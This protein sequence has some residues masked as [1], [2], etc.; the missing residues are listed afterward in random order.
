MAYLAS[1]HKA[2]S[3]RHAVKSNFISSA[4][5]SLIVAKSSRI[6]IYSFEGDG[7][8]LK[9]QFQVYGRITALLTLRPVDSPTDHLFVA[10]DSSNYL[11]VSWDPVQKRVRNEQ[12]ACDVSDK[13]LRNARCGPLYLADPAGRLL[14]LHIYQGTFISIPLAQSPKIMNKKQAKSNLVESF[15]NFDTATPIRFSELD[16]VDMAFLHDTANPVLAIL[17]NSA[18][19]G[20]VHMKTYEITHNGTEFKEWHMKETSLK[21]EPT[22]LIPVPGPVGGLLVLGTQMFCYFNP[23]NRTVQKHLLHQDRSFV[24]W[25]IID[26]QRYLLGDEDGRLHIL[27]IELLRGKVHGIKVEEIGQISVPSRLVYL[28]NGH[29]YVGSHSGDSQLVRLSS[30]EPKVQVIKTFTNLAPVTD[31]RVVDMNYSGLENQQQYSS[32]HMRIVSCSGGFKQGSLRSVKSGLV[33][34]DLGI[35]GDM[36]G[37]RGLWGLK[38]TPGN[39]FDDILVVSFIDETRVFQFHQ[40]DDPEELERFGGFSL[41]ERTLI[42][43]NVTDGKLLQVT[44]SGARLINTGSGEISSQLD[45]RGK[46]II[47]MASANEDTLIYVINGS[48]LFAVDLKAD[49]KEIGTRSFSNEISCLT[50]SIVSSTICAVGQWTTS[51]VSILTLPGL[52]TLSEEI[53]VRTENSAIPR[54][55]L[56][57]RILQ[58]QPPTLLVAMG[59]GTLFTFSVHEESYLLS[60]KKS[61]VLGTQSVYFQP[62]PLGNGLVNVFATCDHPSLIYGLEGRIAY[63]A[64][65]ADRTTHVTPFNAHGFP[66]SVAM[67]TEEDL[68]LAVLDFTR[69]THVR[70]LSTGDVVRR[71]AHLKTREVFGVL[72]INLYQDL[73]TGDEQFKCYVKVVDDI[74]FTMID[75]YEL[76]EAELIE[77]IMCANLSNGDET[78]SERFIVGTGFQEKSKDE[79]TRGRILVFELSDDRKLKLAAELVVRG[80]CKGLDFVNGKIVAALNRTVEMYSW[81]SP[82]SLKPKI[83]KIASYRTHSEPIDLGVRDN[84]IA[85]G[86]LMKGPSLLEYSSQNGIDYK[87][88][89]VARNYQTLWTTAIEL[90]DKETI[91]C[92]DAEGNMSIWRRDVNGVTDEDRKR[93]QLVGEIRIG[94]M[95]NRIRKVDGSVLPGSVV[96]PKAYC[97]TVDGSI[98]LLG[99]IDSEYLDLLMQLQSNMA[100]V[101]SGVGDL[102]FNKFRAYW[103]PSRSSEEPFRFVDG[104][105]IERFLELTDADAERVVDG[106]GKKTDGLSKG[107]DEIR[108]I[109][110]SLRRLH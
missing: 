55:L 11:T 100:K 71:V 10:S 92:G 46:G 65:T 35:L 22:M 32:G 56:L 97:A 18:H 39:Q 84:M 64:V 59:D 99:E 73:T 72:T 108:S 49:L 74:T 87:L 15:K 37:I 54:S 33:M 25:G 103:S 98:Y 66:N 44:P 101:I 36:V 12:A 38:S 67:A 7:L 8:S 13:F 80:S 95:V 61:I 69:S 20:E 1:I 47:N 110:E 60:Q 57:A 89:E 82:L 4:E 50:I 26:T 40:D 85:V 43:G 34:E 77:S 70:N 2:S 31:F 58:D 27:F 93:L 104:D 42:A 30:E 68:K 63:S 51:A 102:D 109:V 41:G 29:L 88:N 79:T 90:W 24:T 107:V 106:V 9:S 6:E 14:G 96:Q 5:Q 53:L 19:P 76:Q 105:F 78:F 86:D 45:L 17:Y 75:F 94:E 3:V 83:V 91:I 81:E 48:T 28:D 21:A 62:I 52:E 16:V 23:E